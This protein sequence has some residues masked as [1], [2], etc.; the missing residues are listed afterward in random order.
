[1]RSRRGTMAVLNKLASL[2]Q[3]DSSQLASIGFRMSGNSSLGERAAARSRRL[4]RRPTSRTTG[5]GQAKAKVWV[6]TGGDDQ[7]VLL[8]HGNQFQAKGRGTR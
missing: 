6:V 4:S 2:T 3:V 8:G 7:L 1:M 5:A